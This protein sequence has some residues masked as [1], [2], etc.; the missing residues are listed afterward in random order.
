MSI[1]NMASLFEIVVETDSSDIE[2]V[3]GG[4]CILADK[5]MA[6]STSLLSALVTAMHRICFAVAKHLKK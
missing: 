1:E 5:N 2:A 6:R 4:V 3:V